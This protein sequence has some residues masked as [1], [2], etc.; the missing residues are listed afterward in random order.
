M[1]FIFQ[2]PNSFGA[3]KKPFVS[4]VNLARIADFFEV[5]YLLTRQYGLHPLPASFEF[6]AVKACALARHVAMK[7][8]IQFLA[9]IDFI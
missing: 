6:V 9:R 4:P 3:L 1:A 8:K 2:L 7:N 5:Y